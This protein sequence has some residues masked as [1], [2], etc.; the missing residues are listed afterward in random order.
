VLAALLLAAA[1]S[2]C[3]HGRGSRSSAPAVDATQDQ[4]PRLVAAADAHLEKGVAELRQGHMGEARLAFD[5]A[6]DVYL[7]APGGA[8]A[9]PALAAAYRRTLETIHVHE[10][11]ALAAGDAFRERQPEPAAIDELRQVRL[12]E[13]HIDAEVRKAAELLVKETDGE[14]PIVVNDAVLSCIEL[15]QGNLRDWFTAALERGGRYL[16]RIRQIFAE[17]RV[18]AELAYTALVESAFKPHALSTA[19][20]K[21]VWQFIPATGKRFGLRQDWWID[22]RSDP[23][24]ATR[25]AAQYLRWLYD[26]L[27]DWNLALA[28]YNSGE[29][30]VLRA[31][32]RENASNF[33]ELHELGAL[34][35]E[36]RNYVP[37]I[38]AAILVAKAPER[39]GFE[40]TPEPL[41]ETDTVQV[42]DA[43]DLRLVAECAGVPLSSVQ[44]L[45]PA[46]RRI[47][48]PA[49]RKFAVHVPEGSGA[50]VSACLDR[51]PGD[52]RVAFR[53]HVVGR[54]QTLSAIA[55][56][57][58]VSTGE[59]AAANSLSGKKTLAKGTELII[60]IEPR[61]VAA[62]TAVTRT[63]QRDDE[64]EEAPAGRRKVQYKIRSGDTLGSIASRYKTTAQDIRTWNGLRNDRLWAGRILTIYTR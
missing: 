37:M 31:L 51:V 17:E 16:P 62:R 23:E 41:L 5:E 48:T 28:G 35:A 4:T 8:Y 50:R 45:N 42:A 60:P 58:G 36:T 7:T 13:P 12:G 59:I 32:E 15:Y 61:A 53:T 18:P 63:A 43:T 27:G 56:R 21:G 20:A 11:D 40:V 57:Y 2:A 22:E 9:N 26:T 1:G 33:W 34:P 10:I 19:K 3:A 46:L 38:H 64:D 25:A 39:Y 55:R 52:K 29:G 49:S 24:K 47:A 44:A 6:V 54:G 14:V 30:R